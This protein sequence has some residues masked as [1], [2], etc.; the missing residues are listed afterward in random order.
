EL[1]IE[2]RIVIDIDGL[3]SGKGNSTGGVGS[4]SDDADNGVDDYPKIYM[5]K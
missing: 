5:K 3:F 4:G 1:K 2:R